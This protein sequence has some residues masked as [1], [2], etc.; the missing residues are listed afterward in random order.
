MGRVGGI[1][2][3]LIS[4]AA[5][6]F[7]LVRYA[8]IRNIEAVNLDDHISVKVEAPDGTLNIYQDS[9]QFEAP[10][11]GSTVRVTVHL[12]ES[13]KID[14]A[15][16]CFYNYNSVVTVT[17]RGHILYKHGT[18]ERQAGRTTG[19]TV[20]RVN[21]PDDAWGNDIRISLYQLEDNTT[22]NIHG[23]Y[24][25]PSTQ[26]WLYPLLTSSQPE[27]VAS[28]SFCT[29]SI[30][31]LVVFVG[32]LLADRSIRQGIYL[33][34]FCL[35]LS[36]WDLGYTSLVYLITDDTVFAPTMEY[37]MLHLVP[38]W[39]FGY[40]RFEC[41][42]TRRAH[43]CLAVE[44]VDAALAAIA[45][46]T[47]LLGVP[48]MGYLGMLKVLY[49]ELVV[50]AAATVATA[51][52]SGTR[53]DASRA[54][55]RYGTGITVVISLLEVLR[56]ILN[57]SSGV[58]RISGALEPFIE[59]TLAP[60]VIV[61]F[62]GTLLASYL[63]HL[64]RMLHARLERQQLE[65]L[66]YTDAL[67]GIPNRASLDERF[68]SLRTSDKLRYTILFFDVD[69]LKV[70]NDELG[71]D[72]GDRLLQ[73]VGR[74]IGEACA[75]YDGFWGRYGGDEFVAV[76][77]RKRDADRAQRSFQSII[78]EAN[79]RSYLPFPVEVAVGRADHE[80]E[81]SLT[82]DE[83]L[84]RADSQMY[85]DKVRREGADAVRG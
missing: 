44:I 10:A 12:P 74:A 68:G 21:V 51:L 41:H 34:L 60:L 1:V 4:L 80:Q 45:L 9:R 26:A 22:S 16:L 6:V 23:V 32:M 58:F 75:G 35:C 18:A 50:M 55:F 82:V 11:K 3:A 59:S 84:K 28:Y 15:A 72:A 39:F 81:E 53:R 13:E 38:V 49:V 77:Y 54:V 79:D 8:G 30:I 42:D 27:F 20:V 63:I 70:T 2:L 29:A 47:E 64:T 85:E 71:H 40:L 76:L 57:R 19:H 66:A 31:L 36:L 56:V 73:L 37:L 33:A 65:R 61:A 62:E 25:M 78:R 24:A 46:T 14:E 52:S 67:T 48:G 83:E 43:V 7:C 5:V 69:R 17:Y